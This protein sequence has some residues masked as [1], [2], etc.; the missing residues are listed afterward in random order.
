MGTFG[1]LG[2]ISIN[3]LDNLLLHLIV[4]ND[5]LYMAADPADKNTPKSSAADLY[6]HQARIWDAMRRQLEAIVW[7][8]HDLQNTL[9]YSASYQQVEQA[10]KEIIALEQEAKSQ[11]ITRKG[12]QYDGR[13][14]FSNE[15]GL[16]MGE[17][18]VVKSEGKFLEVTSI[19]GELIEGIPLKKRQT[20]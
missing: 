8:V 5:E 6:R 17:K 20:Q 12:V 19:D 15:L 14:Y 9:F 18:V 11:K 4:K 2:K 1:N 13:W 7:C 16:H 3:E 10:V